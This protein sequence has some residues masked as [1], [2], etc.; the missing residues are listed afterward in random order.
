[1]KTA[2]ITLHSINNPGSAFQAYALNKYL[3]DNG[4]SNFIINYQP[5]YSII[6]K[7]KIKGIIRVLVFLPNE[8]MI[9]KK[10]VRFMRNQMVLSKKKYYSIVS[11]KKNPPIADI[12]ISGSDQLWNFDYDCGR[13]SAYYLNFVGCERK[14]SYAT[15]IGKKDLDENSLN[16]LITQIEDYDCL[17][18][19]EES[20]A[21]LLT[22]KMERDVRWVCDPV[23]LLA[24]KDYLKFVGTNCYGKYAVVYLSSSSSLLNNALMYIREKMRLIII[25]VGG[26]RKRFDCDIHLKCVGPEEFLNLIYHAELVLSSSF[27]ATAFAHIMH[28]NFAVILP[29]GNEE[30]I[31]S[32]L[33]LTKLTQKILT[34]RSLYDETFSMPNYSEVDLKI[35]NFISKSKAYLIDSITKG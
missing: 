12:Y 14:I 33:N 1:M 22:V 26:N 6:G 25:Q 21:R 18:V 13:D 2:L 5:S 15:S 17:S 28:K 10:Y 35:E 23:F 20:T 8:I 32:L 27:H 19:R 16:Q 11:L 34:E 3:N 7:N 29:R 30:R 4:I 9:R 31:L 24:Q